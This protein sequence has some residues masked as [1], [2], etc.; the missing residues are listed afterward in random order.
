[1]APD[2]WVESGPLYGE[3]E[4]CTLVGHPNHRN[5]HMQR[6]PSD[7]AIA[8][9]LDCSRPLDTVDLI[10]GHRGSY[11]ALPVAGIIF[12][13]TDGSSGSVGC[14]RLTAS[15]RNLED[16]SPSCRCQHRSN[17]RAGEDTEV[18]S[19]HLEWSA[20]G[21][22]LESV[23]IWTGELGGLIGLQF[24]STAAQQQESPHVGECDGPFTAVIRFGEAP[25]E[26]AGLKVIFDENMNEA[27]IE[28]KDTV[29]VGLQA[30]VRD[31]NTE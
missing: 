1:V 4:A 15:S 6:I 16:G 28:L 19:Y 21:S 9:W 5:H 22:C 18:L 17:W 24:V 3:H 8:T 14:N 29:I 11:A 10:H 26:A 20:G 27:L 12:K 31:V 30:L 13:Y 23:R 7:Y 25:T 2:P